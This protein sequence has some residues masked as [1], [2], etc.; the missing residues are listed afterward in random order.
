MDDRFETEMHSAGADTAA[1]GPVRYTAYSQAVIERPPF[2]AEKHEV[3]FSVLSYIAA[4]CYIQFYWD[5]IDAATS[6]AVWT[7]RVCLLAVAAFIMAAGFMPGKGRRACVPENY[8]WLG[9]FACCLAGYYIHFATGISELRSPMD[10][11]PAFINWREGV[12]DQTQI[13]LFIHIFAVWWLLSQSG[14]LLEGRSG[15]LLPADALHGFVVIP[16]GNIILRVRTLAWAVRQAVDARGGKKLKFSARTA[17]AAVISVLLFIGAVSL[18]GSADS[19]FNDYVSDFLEL[20]SF[21]VEASL[22]LRLVLSIPVG[23]WLFGLVAGA[24]RTEREDLDARR[25][26]VISGISS[27]RGVPNALW[28]AVVCA[29]SAVYAAFFVLQAS[30]MLGGFTGRLPEGFIYSQYAREGFF[31]LCRVML[32]NFVLLWLVTRMAKAEEAGGKTLRVLSLIILAES[33]VFAVIA[34]SKLA[35][36]ISVYG[37]TPL[38]LQSSWLVCTL[39]AGCALWAYNIVTGR[40]AFRKWMYFGAVTLSLLALY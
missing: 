14:A 16:F 30:Y 6:R 26:S 12:W 20:F 7:S 1:A 35:L 33:M 40:P 34:L 38:R 11:Y 36:Y 18:L 27:L 9:C 29:F 39:F 5:S 23:A 25:D 3:L 21:D 22:V 32:V 8:V 15:H 24:F 13:L 19:N 31:E 28:I 17:A 2:K 10:E 4:F 37:F